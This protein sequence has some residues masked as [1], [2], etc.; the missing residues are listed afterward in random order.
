MSFYGHVDNIDGKSIRGWLVNRGNLGERCAVAALVAGRVVAEGLA[1]GFRQDLLSSG[2]GDGNYAFSLTIPDEWVQ[3]GPIRI[4]E[5][6]TVAD[7]IG[8]PVQLSVAPAVVATATVVP[9]V[10]SARTGAQVQTKTALA[11]APAAP[12]PAPAPAQIG[13][14]IGFEDDVLELEAFDALLKPQAVLTS[15]VNELTQHP[16]VDHY[17]RLQK[18]IAQN[19][20]AEVLVRELANLMVR[21]DAQELTIARLSAALDL[22]DALLAIPATAATLLPQ[23]TEVSADVFLNDVRG[24]YGLEWDRTGKPYRWT[25][26]E[27]ASMIDLCVDRAEPKAFNLALLKMRPDGRDHACRILVDGQ[28]VPCRIQQ[29]DT[30]V[31]FSGILPA[32]ENRVKTEVCILTPTLYSPAEMNPG[33]GDN[34][35]LGVAFMKL[36]VDKPAATSAGKT[37]GGAS[38]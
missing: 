19:S 7:L 15:Q 24:F 1:E 8:S 30:L 17:E 14:D 29:T 4:V 6:S 5:K 25:G 27:R 21:V 31:V 28:P 34:R 10:G 33:S 38:V 12:A 23:R 26:P 32:A 3:A 37:S 9:A 18:L 13:L 2:I 22:R 20:A 11:I 36:V 16:Q 35:R